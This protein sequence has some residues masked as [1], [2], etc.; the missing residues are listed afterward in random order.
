MPAVPRGIFRRRR[1]SYSAIGQAGAVSGRSR[2]TAIGLVLMVVSIIPTSFTHQDHAMWT[3]NWLGAPGQIT[4]PPNP[5]YEL[6]A[7]D[8]ARV[9]FSPGTVALSIRKDPVTV[10]GITYRYRSGAITGYR[11]QSYVYGYFSARVF[12]P[13]AAGQ[14]VNWPAFWLVGDPYRWPATGE[15]DIFEGLGGHLWWHFHFRDSSGSPASYG[16]DAAGSYCGWHK[17]AV[18]WRPAAIRWFYDGT[19]VGKVTQNITSSPMFPVFSYS[20]T[21]PGSAGCVQHP[22]ACGGAI[23]PRAV[24]RVRN[25]TARP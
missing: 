15:I 11:K 4:H 8:P 23:D 13:C 10:A 7:F 17:F 12:V 21:D 2:L 5:S 16:G 9:A 18:S 20:V 1:P 22:Q 6:E 3:P 25:F 14:V 24:M 19:L